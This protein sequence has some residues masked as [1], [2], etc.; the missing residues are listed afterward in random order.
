MNNLQFISED[1]FMHVCNNTKLQC[2]GFPTLIKIWWPV[3][4]EKQ[5][6]LLVN[7]RREACVRSVSVQ[8]TDLIL[9]VEKVTNL[10]TCSIS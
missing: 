5:L 10:E 3:Q 6:S 9:Y 1:T 4:L 8:K 2:Q 7:F